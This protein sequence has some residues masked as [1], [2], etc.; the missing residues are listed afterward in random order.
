V[1]HQLFDLLTE[2]ELAELTDSIATF[3]VQVPIVVDSNGEIV[4]GHQRKQVADQ[5]GID[6]PVTGIIIDDE[7]S[8]ALKLGAAGLV[9]TV[10]Y[11]VTEL[12]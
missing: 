11:F 9:V 6:C 5:L 10:Y 1:S 3:G 8:T 4:D 12:L 7:T 2:P